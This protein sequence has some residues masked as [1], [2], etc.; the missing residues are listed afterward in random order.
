[1][2]VF[3]C[4]WL[5]R[6][7]FTINTDDA[8]LVEEN[9]DEQRVLDLYS[10]EAFEILSLQ[11]LRVGWSLK[12]PYSFS[13]MGRP[14]IQLPEDVLRIQEVIYQVKPDVIIETGVAHG[15]A[16]V[17]YASLCK[18][19]ETGRVVGVDIKIH[20][21]NRIAIESHELSYLVTLIEGSS[22]D[23]DV[24]TQVRSIVKPEESVLVILDSSHT[25]EHVLQELE[26]YHALVSPGSYII[27]TDGVMKDLWDVPRGN[28]EWKKD[29]P[30]EA[31]R[32]FAHGHPE[33]VLEQP[34]WP[35]NESNLRES[36][37]YWP[38]AWLRRAG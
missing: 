18:A 13:W 33:F 38:G 7:K 28:P 17:L 19:M 23:P 1:M 8:T 25:R 11:W 14:I 24:L 5:M 35:F 27:A 16:L 26:V 4:N 3:K 37:T 2:L 34:A 36:V 29:N 9:G 10:R 31:A 30:Y 22:T 15:G 20:Q 21:H 12:Y 6:M 32:E